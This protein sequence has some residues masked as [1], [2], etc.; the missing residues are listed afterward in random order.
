[1]YVRMARSGQDWRVADGGQPSVDSVEWIGNVVDAS[2]ESYF[3]GGS[4]EKKDNEPT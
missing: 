2:A 3:T 4:F 1:M